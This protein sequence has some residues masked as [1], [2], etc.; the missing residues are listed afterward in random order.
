MVLTNI[1]LITSLISLLS[2]S[3]SSVSFPSSTTTL[4]HLLLESSIFF[5]FN[6]ELHF[7]GTP[8]DSTTLLSLLQH[9]TDLTIGS[10]M[11]R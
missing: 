2:N 10:M 1:L 6:E 11:Y 5:S 4:P 9:M 8:R 3:L 7:S